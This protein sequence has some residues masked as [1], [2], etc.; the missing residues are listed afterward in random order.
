MLRTP[1]PGRQTR[2]TN[3]VGDVAAATIARF[4]EELA[5]AGYRPRTIATYQRALRC[6]AGRELAGATSRR[7]ASAVL[8]ELAELAPSTRATYL[9]AAR[10]FGRWR[11]G[12]R[13]VAELAGVRVRLDRASPRPLSLAEDA[14]LL[15]ASRT[16][17]ARVRLLHALMRDLG[18]RIGEALALDWRDVVL[19][20]GAE[21][22]TV[23]ASKSRSDS[24]VPIDSGGPCGLARLL[25][26]AARRTRAGYVLGHGR[27]P[28][29][30][31]S[32]GAAYDAWG[33]LCRR[34][35][36][37]AS[38]HRMRHTAATAWL[39]RGLDGEIVR[40]LLR[41]ASPA[42]VAR[43]AELAPEELR[44]RLLDGP[45]GPGWDTRPGRLHPVTRRRRK[46]RPPSTVDTP[47]RTRRRRPA[48][49][50][51]ESEHG[52]GSPHPPRAARSG[53]LSREPL[54]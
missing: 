12:G 42:M 1:T 13:H 40:R 44:R 16:A 50:G 48:R 46:G 5:G 4:G 17:P 20:I 45:R 23:R 25:R 14:A 6:P 28:A 39:R 26:L 11:R 32:Y 37:K 2:V 8:G 33:L 10:A 38:P 27:D 19:D 36:V 53:R 24:A 29:R 54:D 43:Y 52:N 7:R 22:V 51:T 31:W 35:R 30:P 34:A 15:A 49:K 41:H 21:L 3:K 47:S 18:L 9:A